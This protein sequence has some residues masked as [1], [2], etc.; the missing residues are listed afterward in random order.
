MLNE[1]R[2]QGGKHLAYVF[3]PCLLILMK[4]WFAVSLIAVLLIDWELRLFY[5]I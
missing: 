5:T 3:Q 4:L 2:F 1:V